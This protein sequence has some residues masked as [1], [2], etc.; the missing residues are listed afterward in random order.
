MSK[1][2]RMILPQWQ[3]GANPDYMIGSEVLSA[4]IPSD[5][6]AETIK[7]P[8][9]KDLNNITNNNGI[10]GRKVLLQQVNEVEDILKLKH[11]DKVITIGG[12][13]SISEAPFDYLSGKYGDKLGV[14]W[15]DVH[16]DI[17]DTTNS[18]H[19]HE[20]VVANLLGYGDKEFN[21][22]TQNKLS[23]NQIMYAGLK[24]D[25]LRSMDHM[26]DDLNIKYATPEQLAHDSEAIL[27]WIK[28]NDF[29]KIAV[30][31]DLDVLS[32]D[33]FRSILPAQPHTNVDDFGAAVGSMTLK[34]VSRVMSD[35]SDNS[36]IVGFNIAEHMPWDAINLRNTLS[37]I[38]IFG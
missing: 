33:D 13:C 35:I 16:P 27:N 29:Q 23:P 30:H 5:N 22:K 38:S 10:S 26:V 14:I 18:H 4:I 6:H 1:T 25:E 11:P 8:V 3:G 2:I 36:E 24:H 12:D 9:N 34:I 19:L 32:P 7:V 31:F 37:K 15:L 28:D 17:S 20:M 21:D